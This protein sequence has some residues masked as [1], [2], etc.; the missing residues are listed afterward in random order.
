MA[1]ITL[2]YNARSSKARAAIENILAT[3]LFVRRNE[4]KRKSG[5][6]LTLEALH[7]AREGKY[8]GVVDTSS[9]EAMTRSIL[10]A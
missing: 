6:E 8:A 4:P 2:D 7:E 10:G 3:G 5:R 1:T 9:V